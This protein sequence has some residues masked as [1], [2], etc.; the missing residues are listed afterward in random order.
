MANDQIN[1]NFLKWCTEQGIDFNG[2]SLVIKETPGK[3]RHIISEKFIA[4]GTILFKIPYTSLINPFTSP[5]SYNAHK[6]KVEET[7]EEDNNDV[8]SEED[9]EENS[10]GTDEWKNLVAVLFQELKKGKASKWYPY[11]QI[12]PSAETHNF[13]N[14]YY[15]SEEELALLAPSRCVERLGLEKIKQM[16]TDIQHD[17]NIS[18]MSFERFLQISSIIMSYSFDVNVKSM[19]PVADL[20][21]ASVNNNAILQVDD[22][23]EEFISMVAVKDIEEGEEVYNIYGDHPNGELLRMYGYVEEGNNNEFAELELSKLMEINPKYKTIIEKIDDVYDLE[24]PLIMESYD[25]YLEGGLISELIVLCEVLANFTD[26]NTEEEL[27]SLIR[28]AFKR[29]IK[30]NQMSIETKRILDTL[31]AGRISEYDVVQN[32]V[33]PAEKG[34][35]KQYMATV[36]TK[37]EL[38]CLEKCTEIIN[39]EYEIVDQKAE[40]QKKKEDERLDK[41]R[42]RMEKRLDRKGGKKARA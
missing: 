22:E 26:E 10:A 34:Y 14:L 33:Y 6:E 19:V 2:N 29:V 13:D 12:L 41:K 3:N 5:I 30:K 16:Y 27:K 15:W 37:G 24:D 1:Q 25:V 42:K 38:E 28:T 21:N 32:K 23:N 9:D 4:E 40:E 17:F 35:S 7:G 31:I 20:L 11:L 8:S 39:N 18:D 36:V